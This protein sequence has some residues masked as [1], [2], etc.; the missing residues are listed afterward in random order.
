MRARSA[1]LQVFL[2]LYLG[3]QVLLPLRAM[4]RDKRATRG[5]FSW[6]MYADAYSCSI[7]YTARDDEGR[8]A[9]VDP[10]SYFPNHASMMKVFHR[11]VL[12]EFHEALCAD[13]GSPHVEGRVT[14]SANGGPW[15]DLVRPGVHLC[16]APRFGVE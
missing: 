10:R 6:N 11:D 14:C 13:L 5:D 16:S 9:P 4:L 12:P 8:T 15:I 1:G 3:L 7:L 2:A